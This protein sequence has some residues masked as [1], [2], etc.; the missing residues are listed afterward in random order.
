M[1]TLLDDYSRFLLIAYGICRCCPT[2]SSI[3]ALLISR[4]DKYGSVYYTDTRIYACI[5]LYIP[6]WE[7]AVVYAFSD[8]TREA[9]T[10]VVT[11]A[12]VFDL[13]S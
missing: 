11:Q 3:L 5:T 4:V 2:S 6:N 8:S 13:C 9:Y 12:G 7:N 10:A 1:V